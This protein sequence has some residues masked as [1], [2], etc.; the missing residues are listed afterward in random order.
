MSRRWWLPTG[1]C[2]QTKNNNPVCLPDSA[3]N[4]SEREVRRSA[5][6]PNVAVLPA[7]LEHFQVVMNGHFVGV[8]Q[9]GV[10]GSVF[11]IFCLSCGNNQY[12]ASLGMAVN[13]QTD[14]HREPVLCRQLEAM[15]SG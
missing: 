2:G 8:F 5:V 11:R 4:N 13:E 14:H 3:D 6:F 9:Q 7:N 12:A 1:K 10:G 15:D